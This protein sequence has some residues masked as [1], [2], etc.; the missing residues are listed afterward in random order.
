MWRSCGL[1]VDDDPVMLK[2][3][4]RLLHVE[5]HR[6]EML[7]VRTLD[8]AYERLAER[9]VDVLVTELRLAG[10]SGVSLLERVNRDHPGITRIIFSAN[11]EREPPVRLAGLT[12]QFLA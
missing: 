8:A 3:F 9:S 7:F 2:A 5:R 11:G 12:H 1:F 4:E 10:E 6:W